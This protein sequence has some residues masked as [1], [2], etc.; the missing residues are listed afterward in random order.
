LVIYENTKKYN[1]TFLKTQ[2]YHITKVL[3]NTEMCIWNPSLIKR[4]ENFTFYA[5]I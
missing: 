3:W 1:A 2:K 4:Q 5:K